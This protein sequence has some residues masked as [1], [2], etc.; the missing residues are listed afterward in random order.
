MTCVIYSARPEAGARLA[1]EYF[2][3]RVAKRNRRPGSRAGRHRWRGIHGWRWGK[4][5]LRFVSESVTPLP[6]WG[7]KIDNEAKPK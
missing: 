5:R 2:V 6:G 7:S 3:F 4:T 1:V